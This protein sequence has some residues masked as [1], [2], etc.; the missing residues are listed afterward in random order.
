MMVE[1]LVIQYTSVIAPVPPTSADC[2]MVFI[3]LGPD[4]CSYI[5]PI[6]NERQDTLPGL[7]IRLGGGDH[8]EVM[9]NRCMAYSSPTLTISTEV[10]LGNKRKTRDEDANENH[11]L[12]QEVMPPLPPDYPESNLGLS[13][14]EEDNKECVFVVTDIDIP[15]VDIIPETDSDS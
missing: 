4:R 1:S 10:D 14:D 11:L 2:E 15:P 8:Q 9:K 6:C 13:Y 5:A 7:Q 3:K 12:E